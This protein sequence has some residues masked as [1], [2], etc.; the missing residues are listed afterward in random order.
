MV[1]IA[2]GKFYKV[3]IGRISFCLLNS[4]LRNVPS[5]CVCLSSVL[6][7]LE[8]VGAER[9][10]FSGRQQGWVGAQPSMGCWS[11]ESGGCSTEQGGVWVGWWEMGREMESW[12]Q[13]AVSED[14]ESGIPIA[15]WVL[16]MLL[17][18]TFK[19]AFRDLTYSTHCCG[20]KLKSPRIQF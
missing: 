11:W 18:Q 12:G 19:F 16:P 1:L 5:V 7:Q 17:I 20:G 10:L 2:L 13:M 4:V 14:I 15:S 3:L 6:L 9:G 8:G